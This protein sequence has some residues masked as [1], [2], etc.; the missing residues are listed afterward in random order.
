MKI[1]LFKRQYVVLAE[2]LTWQQITEAEQKASASLAAQHW[3]FYRHKL[4]STDDVQPWSLLAM[5]KVVLAA[6]RGD[7]VSDWV[8][9]VQD[10]ERKT[11]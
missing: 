10:F 9:E 11:S 1:S 3:H 7:D 8:I 4:G 2:K 6:D 5:P